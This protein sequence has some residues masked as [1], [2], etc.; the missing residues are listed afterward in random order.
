MLTG[1]VNYAVPTMLVAP[2]PALGI[3]L[4]YTLAVVAFALALDGASAGWRRQ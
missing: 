4:A 1:A 2:A 3:L